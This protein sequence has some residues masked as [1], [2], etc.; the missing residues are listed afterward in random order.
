MTDTAE[1]TAAEVPGNASGAGTGPV[2]KTGEGPGGAGE[3]SGVDVSGSSGPLPFA[4]GT[5]VPVGSGAGEDVIARTLP[6]ERLGTP[7]SPMRP[8][9]T[10]VSSVA[11]TSATSQSSPTNSGSSTST[12]SPNRSDSPFRQ[13]ASAGLGSPVSKGGGPVGSTSE[14]PVPD[15]PGPGT[16][17]E[18]EA[19][20]GPEAGA[21][22]G[23]ADPGEAAQA[24]GAGG[25]GKDGRRGG[26]HRGGTARRGRPRRRRRTVLG[27][28]A[29]AM[30]ILLGAIGLVTLT[31]GPDSRRSADAP[32]AS[33][34]PDTAKA[35]GAQPTQPQPE[36]APT[37][38]AGPAGPG[39]RWPSGANG[40]PPLDIRA[41]EA[42]TGRLTNVAVVFT[43]RNDWNGIAYDNWP[44]SDY[45]PGVYNGQLSIAQPLFPRSGDERTCARGH[46]DAYWAAFGQTLTRNGRPD[47]IVRLGWEFN[48]N[49]FWWY[50]RDTATWKTCFQRAVTQIRS[51][52]PAVRIDFNVSAH[53]DRMPNGDDVWAAYPGDEFVSIVSSDAYDSYPPSRSAETFDQQC[54]IPSGACTVAAFARAHGKQFAVPEWGLV[55]VDGNGGGDNPLFIEKMHDLFDR[56]RDILAY[57]AYFSTAEADNVRSSLINPPLNPMAAQRYLE[58]FGAGAG[59]SGSPGGL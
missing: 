12:G 59:G 43:K 31:G 20:A 7:G 53:R 28:V 32:A 29:A 35:P 13:R 34:A 9:K 36:P 19:G 58:L 18:A 6:Y 27:V 39:V 52:A 41:W 42:W 56:N 55:R 44:M 4:A 50:P 49:W 8:D 5:D 57:E 24:P 10:L 14:N 40:N 17:P 46:Y 54:N 22:A 33:Q 21:G 48:G 23:A 51:T 38:P 45:P 3:G 2:P 25:Q 11:R 16:G 26:N 15:G 47:A 1:D 30:V 37:G